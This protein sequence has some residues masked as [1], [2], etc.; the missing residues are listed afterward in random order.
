MTPGPVLYLVCYDICDPK[1]LRK[2]HKVMVGRGDRV[3]YS[4][5]RCA[6]SELQ[7]AVLESV[8]MELIKPSEDQVLFVPLGAVNA[9]KSWKMY[10]IGKPLVPPE[11]VVRIL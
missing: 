1:R 11:R 6:L 8:L 2:V 7:L 10:T 4:V 9:P 3:Q 5:Y